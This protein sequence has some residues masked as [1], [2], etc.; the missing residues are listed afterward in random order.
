MNRKSRVRADVLQA[1]KE[2]IEAK[3]GRRGTRLILKARFGVSISKDTY[4]KLWQEKQSEI[5]YERHTSHKRYNLRRVK[6]KQGRYNT[7]IKIGLLP[8]EAR[9]FSNAQTLL[10]SEFRSIFYQRQSMLK[11]FMSKTGLKPGDQDFNTKFYATIYQYYKRNGLLTLNAKLQQVI[12]PWSLFDKVSS[13]LP[14]EARYSTES[15]RKRIGNAKRKPSENAARLKAISGII[16]TM[17]RQPFRYDELSKQ[18]VN[19]GGRPPSRQRIST[20]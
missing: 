20:L 9:E 15:R 8:E 1:A 10:Y 11:N 14:P 17:R 7:M 4:G 18:I 12:S 19:L 2:L 5:A 13:K 6:G 3:A 16:A